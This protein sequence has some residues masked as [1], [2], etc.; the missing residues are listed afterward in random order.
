MHEKILLQKLLMMSKYAIYCMLLQSM[1]L[2]FVLANNG[3]AQTKKLE[4]IY[5]SLHLKNSSLEEALAKIGEKSDFMF[6]YNDHKVKKNE[7]VSIQS[8]NKP[9]YEILLK[10]SKDHGLKFKRV[11]QNIFVNRVG[12]RDRP[13]EDAINR[14]LAENID[15]SGKIT[16]ENGQALPGASILEK[17]TTNGTITDSEGNYK[18]SAP[19]DATLVISFIGYLSQEVNVGGRTTINVQMTTDLT[20]LQE[21][22]VVGYGTMKEVNVTGSYAQVDGEVLENRPVQ[23]IGQALQGQIANLNISTVGDPG[24]VGTPAT[25]NIRGFTSL[26]GGEPLYVVDGVPVENLQNIN[27]VDV[28]SVTF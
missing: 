5:I 11:D 28:K 24:G 16:D 27:P 18:L 23:N 1:A 22:V 9:L 14:V 10:L 21:V 4:E 7:E 13:V 26:N 8:E 19:E 12:G 25:Y 3:E 2:T 20:H 17:G 15:I 6:V